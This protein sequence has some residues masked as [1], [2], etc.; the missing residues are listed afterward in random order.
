MSDSLRPHKSQHARPPCPS[1]TPRVHSDSRPSS[2]WCH[3]AISSSVVPLGIPKPNWTKY[4]LSQPETSMLYGPWN[5]RVFSPLIKL[6]KLSRVDLHPFFVQCSQAS[7]SMGF[8]RQEYCSGLP[9]PSLWNLPNLGIE[10]GSPALQ[11]D[12]LP[13]KSPGKPIMKLMR[14][15]LLFFTEVLLFEKFWRY[16]KLTWLSQF[17]ALWAIETGKP[18]HINTILTSSFHWNYLVLG[19]SG[20]SNEQ[21]DF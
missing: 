2:Q 21:K 7:L 1:P 8:S 12:S 19:T 9:F 17:G 11:A 10:P 18:K 5:H 14:V 4:V 20:S 6:A 13:S 15:L 3:P 16:K